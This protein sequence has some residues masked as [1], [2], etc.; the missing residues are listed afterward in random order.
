ME[1]TICMIESRLQGTVEPGDQIWHNI[2]H[3]HMRNLIITVVED[4]FPV[5]VD[6]TT[7]SAQADVERS[8]LRPSLP[9]A[10]KKTRTP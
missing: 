5:A 3:M 2:H 4:T 8:K 7:A 10:C 6:V 9:R 1:L